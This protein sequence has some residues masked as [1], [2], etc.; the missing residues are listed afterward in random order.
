MRISTKGRYAIRFMVDL[1]VHDTGNYIA[2]KDVSERQNISVKYLEQIIRQLTAAGYLKSVRGPQG[3]YQLARLPE[4]YRVGD[5]LRTIEGSLAP[6]VC[7][8]DDPNRCGYRGR[9]ATIEMW[10]GLY[11]VVT[12]YLDGISLKELAENSRDKENRP[13]KGEQIINQE[14][15][16]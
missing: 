2:L 16:I 10:E 13:S 6:V 15:R 1:A 11:R 12:D 7:L 5:I 4:E 8:D 9:C 14:N 3:G